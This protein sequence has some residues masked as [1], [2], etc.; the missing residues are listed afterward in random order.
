MSAHIISTGGGVITRKEN[1]SPLHQNGKIVFIHRAL[2]SL[3][4]EDRPLSRQ[5]KL[6]QMYETRLPMYRDFCDLEVTNDST[7]EACASAILEKL[8]KDS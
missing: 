7:P 4:T 1:Y 6:A 8:G 5:Q 3:A 2:N